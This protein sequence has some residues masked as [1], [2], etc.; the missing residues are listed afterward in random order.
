[1]TAHSFF[2]AAGFH[3]ALFLNA[4]RKSDRAL[5]ELEKNSR[6]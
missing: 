3:G 4:S 6:F 2:A 1:M 5:G